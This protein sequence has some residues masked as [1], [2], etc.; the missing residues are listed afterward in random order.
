MPKKDTACISYFSNR[1]IFADAI[2]G[3]LFDGRQVVDGNDLQDGNARLAALLG[4]RGGQLVEDRLERDLLVRAVVKCRE[5]TTFAIFGIEN[6][7]TQDPLMPLRIMH[8]DA[9][10]LHTIC[11]SLAAGPGKCAA[12]AEANFLSRVKQGMKLPPVVSLVIY[13]GPDQW[14]APTS[15]HEM[16]EFRDPALRRLVPNYSINLLQPYELTAKKLTRFRTS[17]GSMLHYAKCVG[18]RPALERLMTQD[19][20][21]KRMDESAARLAQ[22]LDGSAARDIETYRTTEGY[23][24]RNAWTENR[25]LGIKQGLKQGRMEGRMEGRDDTLRQMIDALLEMGISQE[26]L[27]TMLT[28]KF[29]M[30]ESQ[31][32]QRLAH[33]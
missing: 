14:T 19:D 18:N 5:D 8:Y 32:R 12:N 15:L 6:Q 21:F 9:L 16:L 10:T 2:N 13:W 28:T 4:K 25:E 30:T 22:A 29:N 17:L 20:F 3:G 26:A 11:R 24:M 1:Y 23:D 27:A 7:S 33:V 31:A